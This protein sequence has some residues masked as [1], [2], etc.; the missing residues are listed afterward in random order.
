MKKVITENERLQLLGLLTL[1]RQHRI[2][3]SHSEEAMAVIMNE[4]FQ[5]LDWLSD[6]IYDDST[7][8][9]EVLKNMDVRVKG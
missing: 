1:A 3:I 8:I 9:D 6:A 7:T 2:I 4:E 5:N